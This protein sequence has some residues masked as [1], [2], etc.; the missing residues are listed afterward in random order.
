[1]R[2]VSSKGRFVAALMP[3]GQRSPAVAHLAL[4]RSMRHGHR[5]EQLSELLRSGA[6]TLQVTLHSTK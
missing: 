1:M 5:G 3:A 6:Q 2:S 4:Q